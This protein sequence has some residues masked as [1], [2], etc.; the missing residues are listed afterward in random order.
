MSRSVLALAASLSLWLCLAPGCAARGKATI[1]VS[2]AHQAERSSRGL[3]PDSVGKIERS[4][5]DTVYVTTA[6]GVEAIPRSQILEIK[7]PDEGAGAVAAAGAVVGVGAG[8][9]GWF[10][11]DCESFNMRCLRTG[12]LGW[13]GILGGAY[14]VVLSGQFYFKAKRE[15]DRSRRAASPGPRAI[16]VPTAIPGPDGEPPAPGAALLFAF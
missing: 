16:L 12:F 10:I 6:R 14:V 8:V 2:P 4:D 15:G 9:V 3:P 7:H 11:I 13:L 1:E 5:A